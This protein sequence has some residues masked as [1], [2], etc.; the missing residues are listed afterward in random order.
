M[1]KKAISQTSALILILTLASCSKSITIDIMVPAAIDVPQEINTVVV[2]NRS[3]P[4][5]GKGGDNFFEG[6][7]SGESIAGDKKGSEECVKSLVKFLNDMPRF[8]AVLYTGPELPGTG[9]STFPV[10][11]EWEK[12]S[13]LCARYNADMLA[14]LEVFDTDNYIAESASTAMWARAG[15]P[16]VPCWLGHNARRIRHG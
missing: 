16:R 6:L 14:A 11:L 8:N 15:P 9:T 4:A 10:A 2:V 7:I 12:V 5:K 1:L 13:I 3:L